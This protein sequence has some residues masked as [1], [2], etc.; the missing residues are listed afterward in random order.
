MLE[1]AREDVTRRAGVDD[2]LNEI[3]QRCLDPSV[4]DLE[5]PR[6]RR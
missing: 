6:G 1:I 2:Q 4:G 5:V 3:F